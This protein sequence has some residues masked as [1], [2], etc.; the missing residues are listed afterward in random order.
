MSAAFDKSR[1]PFRLVN[2][3]LISPSGHN[4]LGEHIRALVR[5]SPAT[6]KNDEPCV[7]I[8]QSL[9]FVLRLPGPAEHLLI[10]EE[11]DDRA[12][13][14]IFWALNEQN[15]PILIVQDHNS[16]NFEWVS[17]TEDDDWKKLP[18]RGQL[19]KRFTTAKEAM[20]QY[21]DSIVIDKIR[22][23]RHWKTFD[24][25]S[26]A[27]LMDDSIRHG[28]TWA[29]IHAMGMVDRHIVRIPIE[30]I[31][32]TGF[33]REPPIAI[34]DMFPTMPEIKGLEWAKVVFIGYT[35]KG[36]LYV[37]FRE[38]EEIKERAFLRFHLRSFPFNQI[39]KIV[40]KPPM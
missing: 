26:A 25:H 19:V 28:T 33:E 9:A 16:S 35:A 24:V 39:E 18:K 5:V 11:I 20:L 38:E 23:T 7:V 29:M 22:S 2:G 14:E 36:T 31:T 13:L 27:G 8:P 3:N 17:L 21:P 6:A 4:E 15:E 10:D 37:L 32:S 12:V 1:V 34:R 40:A 30:S